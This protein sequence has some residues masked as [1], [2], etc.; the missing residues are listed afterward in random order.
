[1]EQWSTRVYVSPAFHTS[2]L[3]RNKTLHKIYLDTEIDDLNI[4]T[5]LR[6]SLKHS[7]KAFSLTVAPI[8]SSL[9]V[10]PLCLESMVSYFRCHGSR[11]EATFYLGLLQVYFVLES[12]EFVSFLWISAK[13][14]DGKGKGT[15]YVS[16]YV[17]VFRQTSARFVNLI[18]R[19]SIWGMF[20]I[21]KCQKK[22]SIE[23]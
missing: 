18:S 5:G 16:P 10:L 15:F 12:G 2:Y 7:L 11:T 22:L 23:Q 20:Q 21:G 9:V 4:L 13:E 3:T 14:T 17:A 8:L 1:M 6:H 19:Y